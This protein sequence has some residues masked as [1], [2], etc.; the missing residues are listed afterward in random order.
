MRAIMLMYDTLKRDY[1]SCYGCQWTHTP[2][3]ERLAQKTVK[4]EKSYIGSFPCIPA[5]RELHTG[6][7]NFLHRSWGPLEPFDDSMPEILARAGIYTH[8]ISDHKHYWED[9]GCTYHDRYHTWEIV[10]G[11]QGDRWKAVVG[12]PQSSPSLP[13]VLDEIN[14]QY[15]DTEDKMPQSMTFQLGL[16]FLQTNLKA[17]NWF[18]H[19][20]TFD[21][22][23][24]FYSPDSYMKLCGFE[25]EP[26]GEDWPPYSKYVDEDEGYVSHMRHTYAALLAMCDAKLGLLLDFMDEHDMWK[27]TMLIVNTDHGFMLG[28]HDMWAKGMHPMYEEVCHTPLFVWDPRVGIQGESRNALVQTIDL[29]PTLLEFFGQ[30]IPK[31]MLG[32][33]LRPVL[34]NDAPI[35][36]GA[37]F[38]AHGG[39]VNVT[40]GRYVYMRDFAPGSG[41]RPLYEYTLMPTHMH[42][43]FTVEQIKTMQY[44]APFAFT[45]DAPLMRFD[46]GMRQRTFPPLPGARPELPP[47]APGLLAYQA[48][49]AQ[50]GHHVLYDLENDPEQNHPVND[51]AIESRMIQ[52]LL[53]LM[54]QNDAPAEQYERLG[55]PLK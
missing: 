25:N 47:P 19:L 15:T 35:H 31:D 38:G 39:T 2:N 52:L 17:D 1:L 48:Y 3:F 20:E 27:D 6:R 11:Q 24:P 9:G 29:A 40:D 13:R 36:E 44:S 49:A 50:G 43:M 37:L 54:R 42:H 41:N 55:L 22:H 5:R 46:G 4:F 45:K 21:P 23:E 51:P 53:R 28:E 18:L 8:L 26:D 16:E 7:Y 34:E 33:P 32:K 30:P 14:R 10:R 12:Y